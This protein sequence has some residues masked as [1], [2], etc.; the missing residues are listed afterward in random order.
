MGKNIGSRIIEACGIVEELGPASYRQVYERMEGV[1]LENAGK[2][3]ERA[4]GHGLMTADRSVY[5]KRFSVVPGW[6]G[7]VKDL[8]VKLRKLPVRGKPWTADFVVCAA[9]R[10]QVNSIF[11]F[12]ARP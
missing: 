7:K 4:V 5:P 12:G 1:A 2:Y 10:T 6:T 3:C 8:K 9:M 11:G